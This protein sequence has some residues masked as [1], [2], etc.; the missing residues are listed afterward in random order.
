VGAAVIIDTKQAK[1]KEKRG[2]RRKKGKG[3]REKGYPGE[4]FH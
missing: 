4:F 2:E 3:K 1:N